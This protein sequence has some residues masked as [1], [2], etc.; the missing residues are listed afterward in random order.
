MKKWLFTLL[1]GYAAGLAVAMKFRKD[2]G[3]SK[4]PADTKDTTVEGFISEVV[5][6]HRV[7]FDEAKKFFDEH[8][9]DVNDFASLQA[10]V[11]GI[12]AGFIPEIESKVQ[13]LSAKG[14][15][16]KKMALDLIEKAYG[17]KQAFLQNAQ[18]KAERFVDT[19][20]DVLQSWIA[21]ATKKLDTA[22]E[23]LKNETQENPPQA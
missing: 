14:D 18:A 19:G 9:E 8:F 15:E 12:I 1:A 16:K 5:D 3:A 4:L 17:E 6:I 10:K 20:S 11:E 21:E 2:A 23:K 7:A 22:Y 13:A